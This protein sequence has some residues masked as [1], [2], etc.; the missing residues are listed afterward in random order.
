M[1]SKKYT[2]WIIMLIVALNSIGFSIVLPLLPFLV[3]KYLPS[4][5]VVVGMSALLSVFAACTFFAAPVL[6]ALSD[7]YGRKKILM[8]SLFGSVIG[9]ILFGIGGALWVLFLGRIID[10]LTAGN[11]STLFAY[12]SDTIAPKE[13]IKWFGYI[14]AVMGT[15]KIG[16]PAL[17]GLLGN[18]SIGLPF[19]VTAA[20]IFLSGLAVYFLLPE[21]LPPEKRTKQLTLASMNTFYLFKEIFSLKA[22]KLLLLLGALFY[23]GLGIF[24]FNFT[25]FLK[26]VYHWGPQLIG[27]LL[28]VVGVFDIVTR[29]VL[30]PRLLKHYSEKSIA[31]AG[32]I[33]LGIGLGLILASIYLHSLII[34]SLAVIFII[35]GEGLFEST[36]NGKLSQ[37]VSESQ[38]GKLQGVSQSLQSANN[39]FVPLAAAAI[40]FYNPGALYAV[41]TLIILAAVG[42]C[43]KYIPRTKPT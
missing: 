19:Y 15:G 20:L 41:A 36:Y 18:I 29:A 39:M 43:A 17:G 3:G 40:Y 33:G 10:G 42:M 31:I 1:K 9:Y 25:V 26:D 22:V 8:V 38:Q 11:I 28:T 5:Q 16:G 12:L 7:R 37:S 32:L 13:R 4:R 30:L 14:G 27:I 21:S 6:G 35:S 2:L 34:I 23:A 24:Q